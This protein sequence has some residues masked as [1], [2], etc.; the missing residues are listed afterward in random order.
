MCGPQNSVSHIRSLG[1]D[2]F[3][4]IIDHSYDAIPDWR[5]RINA[6]HR[7]LD[8]II[9][10]DQQALITSTFERR[11]K[12]SELLASRDIIEKFVY[13]MAKNILKLVNT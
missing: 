9:K 11:Q 1:L 6:M 3:D 13:P 12:N 8:N 10:L 4:D 2:V 7:E 5:M